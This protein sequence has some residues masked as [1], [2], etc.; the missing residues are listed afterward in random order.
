MKKEVLKGEVPNGKKNMQFN[1]F[2]T[3]N[4]RK[5][6]DEM[7]NFSAILVGGPSKRYYIYFISCFGFWVE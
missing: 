5:N 3:P 6:S 1:F 7:E 2:V 4:L